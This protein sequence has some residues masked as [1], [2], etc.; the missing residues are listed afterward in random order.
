MGCPHCKKDLTDIKWPAKGDI[1][2]ACWNDAGVEL[3]VEEPG[4]GKE[5][6]KTL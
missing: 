3:V 2:K 4:N 1:C 5:A 6:K